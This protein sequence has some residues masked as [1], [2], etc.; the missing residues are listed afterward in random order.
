V[1]GED[2][3]YIQN[4]PAYHVTHVYGNVLIERADDGNRQMVHYGG[5]SANTGIYR[6]GTLHFYNNTL[7]S[8]RTDRNTFFRLSTNAETADVRNNIFYTTLAGSG[9]ALLDATGVLRVSRNWIKAG[10]RG[11]FSISNPQVQDDG[12][13][14]NG[15]SPGFVSEAGQDFHLTA[16]S[17]AVNAGGNLNAAV[18]PQ[19]S[20]TRQYVKH[21]LTEARPTDGLFDIGAFE[22]N[23]APA[24]TV[25]QPPVAA[26][27]L[28]AASGNT[29][30]TI[31]FSSTGSHDPDGS[32]A[33][34]RWT[35]GNGA[36]ASGPAAAY[37]YTTAGT[38][39]ATLEVTDDKGA[40]AS[41]SR[42]VT[43]TPPPLQKPGTP[44]L[45]A[46][47]K[48]ATVTL[49]WPAPGGGAATGYRI[50]RR[51]P[52]GVW[53]LLATVTARTYTTVLPN[54]QS[55]GYRVQAYNAAGASAW[56]TPVTVRIR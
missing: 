1:D 49:S 6:K 54:R 23:G 31:S 37:T 35:F 32:I 7:V 40:K 19:H 3:A 17:G 20:V 21:R 52:A 47:L 30:L 2:T 50:E 36:S 44:V 12:T 4:D 18:L 16:A 8:Y 46:A 56:S 14:E 22:L 48:G 25:N 38:F 41:A 53:S 39:T 26:L 34:Y 45:T 55:W 29:P 33:S 9:N 42:T 11:S 24:P 28:S 43:V 13:W 51:T 27:S 10:W 15:S 5:D